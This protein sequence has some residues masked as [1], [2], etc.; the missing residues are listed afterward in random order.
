MF[1]FLTW[2]PAAACSS[3]GFLSKVWFSSKD[4]YKFDSYNYTLVKMVSTILALFTVG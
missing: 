2:L 1:S 4:K 3:A